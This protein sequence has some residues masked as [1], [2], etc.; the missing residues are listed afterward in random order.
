MSSAGRYILWT[1]YGCE[2]WRP[3]RYESLEAAIQAV[4]DAH[5]GLAVLTEEIP[6]VDRRKLQTQAH[7]QGSEEE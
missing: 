2:G 6:L 7:A 3:T 4:L 5:Y 1:D